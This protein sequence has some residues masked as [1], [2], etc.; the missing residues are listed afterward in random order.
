MREF[1]NEVT[2]FLCLD[3][4]VPTYLNRMHF[5]T[6]CPIVW[7]KWNNVLNSHR[8]FLRL[9]F[10]QNNNLNL[11]VPNHMGI[12]FPNN[13]NIHIIMDN[14]NINNNSTICHMDHF[15]NPWNLSS[16]L[17]INP[18]ILLLNP[19]FFS[20]NTCAMEIKCF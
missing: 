11:E 1:N 13:T 18:Y 19:H 15:Q 2:F 10:F 17:W 8:S 20:W 3:T 16:Y 5:L 9:D 14:N 4:I 12:F 6:I 7:Q